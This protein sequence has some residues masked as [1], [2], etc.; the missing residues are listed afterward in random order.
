M[1]MRTTIGLSLAL[2]ILS[3]AAWVKQVHAAVHHHPAP[4]A[5]AKHAKG[6]AAGRTTRRRPAGTVAAAAAAAIAHAEHRRRGR[7]LVRRPVVASAG[8]RR[9]SHLRRQVAMLPP[10]DRYISPLRSIGP[11]EIGEAAWYGGRHVGERTAS[12]ERLDTI[13]PTAAHRTLPLHSLVRVTNLTNGRS[14]VATINDRGPVSHSLLI[15]L[16]PRVAEELDMMRAG[17]ARVRIE[18]VAAAAATGGPAR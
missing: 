1:R 2:L 11:V 14:T 6:V 18:P 16:S 10:P 13:H 5:K 4:S 17:I 12:G 3:A 9:R 7:H 8:S 15:D